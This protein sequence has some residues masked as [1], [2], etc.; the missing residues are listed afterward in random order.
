LV[1]DLMFVD[2]PVLG[3]TLAEMVRLPSGGLADDTAVLCARRRRI[4]AAK[5]RIDLLAGG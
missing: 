4:T 2:F 3:K 1:A 5:Q